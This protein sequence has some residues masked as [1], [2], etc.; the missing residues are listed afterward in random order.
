V[1]LIIGLAG[2]APHRCAPLSSNVRPHKLGP[3]IIAPMAISKVHLFID[4]SNIF[5]SAQDEAR[6][7]EGNAARLRV[8][9]QFDNLIK[10]ALVGR[11]LGSA[12]VVGSIPPDQQEVWDRL[13]QATGVKPELYERGQFTG[14]E[15]GLDQC[16]QVHMLRAVSDHPDP[17]VAVL[18]TGDG[19]GYDDNIGFHADLERMHAAGWGVEVVSWR[20]HCKRG[21][22][23]WATNNGAFV[24]LDEY[25]DSVTFQEGGRFSNAIDLSTRPLSTPRLSP[26][27]AALE[28]AQLQAAVQ[29]ESLKRELQE[30]QEAAA[31]KA[32]KKAKYEKSFSRGKR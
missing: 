28:K 8:R 30:L 3:L 6:K 21:L 4:N 7:R 22:R 27:K 13:E 5:I 1:L 24:A 10:L 15:Q 9:L 25:Y 11:A 19:A 2:Q 12:F 17:Q 32:S 18:M 29:V 26:A 31:V 16:L 23:E 20:T 14:G